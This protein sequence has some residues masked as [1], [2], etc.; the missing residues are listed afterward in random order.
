MAT[1]TQ[2]ATQETVYYTWYGSCQNEPCEPF[3]LGPQK[4]ILKSVMQLNE[5]GVGSK[6]WQAA[7][8]DFFQPFT[9]L[10]CGHAYRIVVKKGFGSAEIPGLTISGTEDKNYGM[11]TNQ[12]VAPATPTPT[13]TST[14]TPSPTPTLTPSDCCFDLENSVTTTGSLD[15]TADVNGVTP[16]LFE[17][18]GT[19]CFDSLNITN[20]PGRFNIGTADNSIFGYVTTKGTFVNNR[21]V[22]KSPT[23]GLCYEVNLE[24]ESGTNELKPL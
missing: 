1:L 3:P 13:P 16:F 22:Y 7:L 11:L 15:E 14:P 6:A 4:D 9:D 5:T 17:D 2:T 23:T 21:F 18:G 12:C 20:T 8:P 24:S 19:L 10:E